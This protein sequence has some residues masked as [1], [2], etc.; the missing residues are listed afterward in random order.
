MA[1]S[2]TQLS[3]A[4]IAS[5]LLYRYLSAQHRRQP[6]KP[7]NSRYCTTCY[8]PIEL[9]TVP[10]TTRLRST[11]GATSI[12]E[13]LLI[14][15]LPL[16]FQTRI[17]DS[18]YFSS[19]V[20]TLTIIG[21]FIFFLLKPWLFVKFLSTHNIQHNV[22]YSKQ[23][24]RL[25]CDVYHHGTTDAVPVDSTAATTATNSNSNQLHLRSGQTVSLI[26]L[27]PVIVFVHGGAW[28][29]GSKY[30]YRLYGHFL[31]DAGYVT[32]IPNYRVFPFVKLADDQANDISACVSWVH[33]NIHQYGGDGQQ[34]FMAGH[35]SGGHIISLMYFRWLANKTVAQHPP[36]RGLI[37]IAAPFNIAAHYAFEQGRGVHEI[38]P[39]KVSDPSFAPS[40]VVAPSVG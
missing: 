1:P 29:S 8:S 37:P 32:V 19:I 4:A 12:V 39:M 3:L 17:R 2:R 30:L 36:I 31:R 18:G 23:S 22:Q 16:A 5:V 10:S 6:C 20:D 15:A 26:K 9:I 35:S 11:Q 40:V 27:K 14:R 13:Y 24:K 25:Y 28:S 7:H 21:G 33:Q 38:S 34:I